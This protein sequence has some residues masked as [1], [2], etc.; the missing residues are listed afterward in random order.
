ML[1][2]SRSVPVLL[3]LMITALASSVPTSVAHV[4]TNRVATTIYLPFITNNDSTAPFGFEPNTSLNNST[5]MDQARQLGTGWVRLNARISWRNLQANPGDPIAWGQLASFES[6]LRTLRAAHITPLII[7]DDFP[8]WATIYPTSC[9]ALRTDA[10]DDYAAF[11]QAL[12]QRYKGMEFNV[13]NW[14]L[15]NEPDIDRTLIPVDNFYGC[16]GDIQDEFYG[17]RQY[18]EMLKVVGPAIKAADRTAQVWMGGILLDRP[19]TNVVG[20]GHPEKFFEGIMVAGAAPYFDI[21]A[22]HAYPSYN[23]QFQFDPEKIPG[24]PWAAYGGVISGKAKFLQDVMRT[25][26]VSKPLG[27]NE[28]ALMCPSDLPGATFCRPPTD[29]FY[30]KQATFMTRGFVR[31]L[32]AGVSGFIWYTLDSPGWRYTSLLSDSVTPRKSFYAMKTLSAQLSYTTF[33]GTVNYGPG[34]EAYTFQRSN[35]EK[36]DVIFVTETGATNPTASTKVQIAV[37]TATLLN[38][39]DYL[40]AS[41][42]PVATSGTSIAWYEVDFRPIFITRTVATP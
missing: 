40:G 24:T 21:V 42:A 28:T 41:V 35:G 30:L 5:L 25:Y 20:R 33:V 31:G 1:R 17:G 11:M 6:E 7:V 27:L 4:A 13:H 22:Y 15:G 12:V 36:V 16:W 32:V 2:R 29:D 10:F 34:V 3:L 14:E 39:V 23:G 19:S 38:V 37:P 9:G 26:G 8:R 18:G